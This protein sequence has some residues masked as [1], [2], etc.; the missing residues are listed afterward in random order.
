MRYSLLNFIE[1][2]ASK[3]ELSCLATK[4][5][6]IALPHF[7]LSDCRRVNQPGQVVGPVPPFQRE[8]ALTDALRR[9]SSQPAPPSR[10]LEVEVEEG[11]LVSGETSRWYPI[12]NFIPEIL[13]DHL[14]DLRRDVEFLH[15]LRPLLPASIFQLL[16]GEQAFTNRLAADSGRHYK[17][18]EMGIAEKVDDPQFWG[19]GYLSPFNPGNTEHTAHLIRLFAVCLTL[20]EPHKHRPVLDT[21]SGYSWT[22]EWLLKCGFEPIGVDITRIYME[23]GMHRMGVARPYLVVADT[24]NLPIRSGAVDVVLGFDSFHHIPDRCRA[25]REFSRVLAA[26]GEVVL[27]E[28][29]GAHENDPGAKAVMDKYGILE[30]GMDLEDVR[31]YIAGTTFEPPRQNFICRLSGEDFGSAI[32]PDLEQ[33]SWTSANVFSIRAP[34]ARSGANVNISSR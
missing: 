32:M 3:T 9:L 11:I 21:G 18:A 16:D 33:R 1:C 6:P 17:Q 20:I 14:R 22:T 23:V 2:P 19:P 15:S 12:R 10:N 25:M 28:P 30:R 4:E 27:G 8:T 5:V 13:P 31:R 7:R 24:E 34:S 29:G 26:G